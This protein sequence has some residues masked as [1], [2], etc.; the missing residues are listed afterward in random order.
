MGRAVS[1][2]WINTVAFSGSEEGNMQR[3]KQNSYKVDRGG[4]GRIDELISPA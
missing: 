4:Q 3:K 1:V 2:V